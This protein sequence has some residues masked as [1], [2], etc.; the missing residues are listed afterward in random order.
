M[1]MDHAAATGA[2]VIL[3]FDGVAVEVAP[4]EIAADIAR[5]FATTEQMV[6]ERLS[7]H[8]M[9]SD[10]S[11]MVRTGDVIETMTADHFTRIDRGTFG[12]VTE[13][14]KGETG[15]SGITVRFA[16][17]T[18]DYEAADFVTLRFAR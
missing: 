14:V 10:G 9:L 3:V 5:N 7:R 2:A 17:R 16:R 12:L 11:R 15:A 8:P 4:G 13:V 1:A 18:V 6:A